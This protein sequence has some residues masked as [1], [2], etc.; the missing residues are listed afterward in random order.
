MNRAVEPPRVLRKI[1]VFDPADGFGPVKD[2]VELLDATL[3]KRGNRWWLFLAGQHHG[4]QEITLFSASLPEGAA[5]SPTG[6]NLTTAAGNPAAIEPLG[7]APNGSGGRHCPSYV[8]GWDPARQVEV[9]RIYYARD[10]GQ[11]WGPYVIA[12]LEWDGKQWVNRPEPAFIPTQDWEKGSVY[13]PNLIYTNGKWRIWYVSG[14][15]QDDYLVHGYSESADGRTNWS[16]PRV[17]AQNDLKIFD[18]RVFL[19]QKGHEAVFSRVWVG[20]G[21]SPES[22]GLWWCHCDDPSGDLS[23]WSEPVQLMGAADCG[24]HSGPWKPSV[25]RGEAFP[26]QLLIFFDGIYRIDVAGP[27]PFTFTLGCLECSDGSV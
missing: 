13:E 7:G 15:N 24:W 18:F 20:G 5:L 23:D 10:G 11:P 22:T 9:E 2:V 6:W 14:A 27:F 17:F 4:T 21:R 16:K 1:K 26:G 12:F 8:K 3:A 25:H 19:G